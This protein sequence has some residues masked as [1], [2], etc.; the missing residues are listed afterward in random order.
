MMSWVCD[1]KK[2]LCNVFIALISYLTKHRGSPASV[3]KKFGFASG[4]FH[5]GCW[6]A[7]RSC[8]VAQK[9]VNYLQEVCK[10]KLKIKDF[11]WDKTELSRVM[12]QLNVKIC[13]LI[14]NDH[15]PGSRWYFFRLTHTAVL[16]QWMMSVGNTSL[17]IIQSTYGGEWN[18]PQLKYVSISQ[19][20]LRCAWSLPNSFTNF[21]SCRVCQWFT[22]GERIEIVQPLSLHSSLPPP[23]QQQ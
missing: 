13:F 9:L 21:D 7:P 2:E 11:G 20:S 17:L 6:N 3:L 4:L 5:C 18:I 14:K 22:S 16:P 23:Q 12:I 15:S 1:K 10:W 19:M 8:F